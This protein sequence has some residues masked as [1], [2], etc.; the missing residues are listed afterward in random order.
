M[1]K[2]LLVGA[3]GVALIATGIGGTAAYASMNKKVTVSV[4]GQSRDVSTFDS[5]VGDVLAS[6]NVTV[7]SRDVVAPALNTKVSDGT[8]IAVRYARELKLSVDGKDHSYWVT[9]TDVSNALSELG[10]R[11]D[12]AKLSA[13]RSAGIGRTGLDV[14]IAT[15][16]NVT[17]IHD[18]KKQKVATTALTVGD[19]L[20]AAKVKVDGDDTVSAKLAAPV[21]TGSSITVVR[22]DTKVS[23]VKATVAYATVRKNDSSLTKGKT[24]VERSGVSGQKVTTVK[25]TY[26]D[27]KLTSTKVVSTKQTKKPVGEVILIG[28]K[29][30]PAP[31]P[32]TSSSSGSSSSSSSSSSSAGS[33][34]GRAGGL[35]W[36]ALAQCES[37]GN[38]SIVSAGGSFYGLYQ[39]TP[40]TWHAVGGSGL[41]SQASPGEQTYRA[42]ILYNRAGAGQWPVCGSRLFS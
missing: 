38:P 35:N 13:S 29:P 20:S 32:S 31:K 37:G 16:K 41:P 5:T 19:A 14:D 11:F 18:H 40:S 1:Q 24:K 22:I 10:L 17:V 4:D 21:K 15:R 42:Q 2:K 34:G 27:D 8:R 6:Q 28:T 7:G 30:L 12:G 39:F 23:K 26:R 36:G 3:L 9:S 33:A 25:K